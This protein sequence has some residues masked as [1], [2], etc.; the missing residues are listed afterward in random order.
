MNWDIQTFDFLVDDIYIE[1]CLGWHII[2][3]F[4]FYKKNIILKINNKKEKNIWNEG[5]G[6]EEYHIDAHP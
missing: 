1:L 6:C 4:F 5:K 3:R 2:F